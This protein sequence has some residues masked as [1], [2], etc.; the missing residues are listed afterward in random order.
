MHVRHKHAVEKLGDHFDPGLRPLPDVA[1]GMEVIKAAGRK[2]HA[3]E[4]FRKGAFGKVAH[5]G[6]VAA[7]V[8]RIGRVRHER[9]ESPLGRPGAKRR[10]IALLHSGRRAAARIAREKSKCI[11]AERRGALSHCHVPSGRGYMVAEIQ[12]IG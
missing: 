6:L 3:F 12:C 11:R 1:A 8:E 7:R 10:G 2:L 9:T 5:R 4:I